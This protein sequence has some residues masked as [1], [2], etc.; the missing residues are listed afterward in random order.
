MRPIGWP[1]PTPSRGWSGLTSENQP[2]PPPIFLSLLV[3]AVVSQRVAMGDRG[4][5]LFIYIIDPSKP[6]CS[7]G[8]DVEHF[9]AKNTWI[10]C[11]KCSIICAIYVQWKSLQKKLKKF[12][13]LKTK[14]HRG[15]EASKM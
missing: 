9:F 5:H 3:K 6:R 13:L 8:S 2:V 12:F 10:C 11:F 14:G 1:S 15:R 7:L 4:L